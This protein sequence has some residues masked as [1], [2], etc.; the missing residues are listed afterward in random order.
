MDSH[1]SII[2]AI[3]RGSLSSH[4]TR[5]MLLRHAAALS[6]VVV[7]SVAVG[8]GFGVVGMLE[9]TGAACLITFLPL[10]R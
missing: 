10:A 7:A 2:N 6:A 8:G 9:A 5:T 4:Q 3:Q 1:V